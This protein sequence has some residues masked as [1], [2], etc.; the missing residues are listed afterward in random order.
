LFRQTV[1]KTGFF[2]KIRILDSSTKP[3]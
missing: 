1:S 3:I 2:E